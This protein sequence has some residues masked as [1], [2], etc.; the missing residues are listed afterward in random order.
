MPFAGG[1]GERMLIAMTALVVVGAALATTAWWLLRHTRA[2]SVPAIVAGR[3]VA[4]G[5]LGG[6]A[7]VPVGMALLAAG[8]EVNK[9][10]QLLI[11]RVLGQFLYSAMA[12]EH[13]AVSIA[14]A[15][16]FVALQLRRP[17]RHTVLLGAGYGAL[18]WLLV[19]SLAL[20]VVFGQPT[21]WQLGVSAIW[22]SLLVHVVYGLV[23]ALVVSRDQRKYAELP[24]VGGRQSAPSYGYGH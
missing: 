1:P 3:S 5:V 23:L 12:I 18:A 13:F 16:P 20:P 4:A 15:V 8:L 19:N 2:R 14:L 6:V 9:Y 7:M 22:P 17:S 21:P 24:V 10:G 11:E